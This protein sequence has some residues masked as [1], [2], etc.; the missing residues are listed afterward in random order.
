MFVRRIHESFSKLPPKEPVGHIGTQRE[1]TLSIITSSTSSVRWT[2]NPNIVVPGSGRD[3]DLSLWF[4]I[5]G[6]GST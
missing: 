2:L 3:V 5:L 4:R 6:S 1:S